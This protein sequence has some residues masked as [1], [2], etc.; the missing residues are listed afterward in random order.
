[1]S[2]LPSTRNDVLPYGRQTIDAQ[3]IAAVVEVLQSDWLTTGPKVREFESRMAEQVGVAHAV[4]VSNG[5]AALHAIMHAIGIGP[6]D[7]VIVPTL[8]FAASANCVVYQGGTPVFA[9]VDPDTLLLD[10][11]AVEAAITERTKAIIAVDYA[12]QPCDYDRLQA[13]A[14]QHDIALVADACHSLGGTYNERPVGSLALASAFSFHPVKL[15][16][17]GEGGMIVTDDDALAERMRIFRNHGISTDHHQRQSAGTWHYEMRSLGFNYRL[18]DLQC[19]LGISQLNKLD[20]WI[21]RRQEIA[22]Q[23]D[24]AFAA[25]PQI[26]P[27]TVRQ[28]AS[29]A[30]HLYVIRWIAE[31]SEIDRAA[32]F[33]QLRDSGLAVNVHYQPVHLHPFYRE[34]YATQI[35]QCPVAEAAYEQMIS[36]PMFPAM[37]DVDVDRVIKTVSE[38]T[39]NARCK[40]A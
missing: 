39:S 7:E 19:A 29:S 10:P 36:L 35:G 34:Q 15:M 13:I 25:L 30:Y 17:T 38:L 11:Q 31:L 20:G 5:T 26:Q 22:A 24:T 14:D 9:D 2:S 37:S 6:G 16:T 21:R 40:A 32:A 1:M 28:E 4:A 23:Y 8:T 33:S 3:D 18:S 27:L 12:G